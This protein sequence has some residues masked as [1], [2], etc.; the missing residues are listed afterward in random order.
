LTAAHEKEL[1]DVSKMY[2]IELEKQERSLFEVVRVSYV[3]Q[4]SV[5]LTDAA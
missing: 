3:T 2:K 4:P 5:V 1:P